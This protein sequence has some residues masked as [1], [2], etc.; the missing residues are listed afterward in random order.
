[1]TKPEEKPVKTPDWVPAM[2]I[3]VRLS[4]WI[5]APLL[6]GLFLGKYL[7]EQNQ[8]SPF[9]FLMCTGAAFV[10]SIAGLII[11]TLKIYKEIDPENKSE[12]KKEK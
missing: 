7:D 2:K 10:I 4:V 9:W 1:M 5:A 8:T 12:N 3:F 11:D 6:L